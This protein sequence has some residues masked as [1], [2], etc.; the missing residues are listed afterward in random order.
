MVVPKV[1]LVANSTLNQLESFLKN[2]ATMFLKKTSQH[3]SN[4]TS[5]LD[6]IL[7]ETMQRSFLGLV[8]IQT[9]LGDYFQAS[10]SSKWHLN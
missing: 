9:S 2:D 3:L 7:R 8:N 6:V 5:D 4:T 10:S 1:P